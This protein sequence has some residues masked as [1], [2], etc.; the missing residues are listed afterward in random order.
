MNVKMTVIDIVACILWILG[1]TRMLLSV[2]LPD[3]KRVSLPHNHIVSLCSSWCAR[4]MTAFGSMPKTQ[5]KDIKITEDLTQYVKDTRALWPLVEEAR[6]QK[7]AGFKGPFAI[8]D[9]R[10]SSVEGLI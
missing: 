6:Q 3:R 10:R 9:C 2:W 5:T 8:I 7:I 1:K 4:H